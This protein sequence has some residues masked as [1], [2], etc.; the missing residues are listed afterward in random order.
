M[1]PEL[2]TSIQKAAIEDTKSQG[3]PVVA[4]C[5]MNPTWI[6]EDVGLIPGLTQ[7]VKDPVSL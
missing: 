6:H 4:P 5:L 3:V 7:W 2:A 1:G